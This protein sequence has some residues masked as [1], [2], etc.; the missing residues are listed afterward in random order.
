MP[1]ILKFT[2]KNVCSY[3][4]KEQEIPFGTDPTLTLIVGENGAGKTTIGN[5][6]EFSM[7]GRTRKRKLKELA[8]RLNGHLE[9]YN[10]FLTD[11]GR[12][13]EVA[14]GIEP[15][16]FELKVD[17]EPDNKA[18]KTRID[19][20]I[21]NELLDIPFEVCTNTMIL[22]INDFKSFV[23]IKAEDKRKIVD[24]IFGTDILNKMNALLK[25]DLKTA[26]EDLEKVDAIIQHQSAL[27]AQWDAQ[28]A[29]LK[30]NLSDEATRR[31]AELERLLSEIG[32]TIGELSLEI[33]T[34]TAETNALIREMQ[35]KV[36][37]VSAG[38]SDADSIAM[39]ELMQAE[40]FCDGEKRREYDVIDAEQRVALEALDASYE[41]IIGKLVQEVTDATA[42]LQR[43]YDE[44]MVAIQSEFDAAT[45]K[46]NEKHNEN[47]RTSFENSVRQKEEILDAYTSNV[48]DVNIRLESAITE[49]NR[50]GEIVGGY[51]LK[52]NTCYANI[53]NAE[54]KLE[55][56]DS[57]KCPE[58][59]GELAGDFHDI[60]KSKIIEEIDNSKREK[61]E[62]ATLKTQTDLLMTEQLKLQ[63]E[64]NAELRSLQTEFDAANKRVD[65]TKRVDDCGSR[66]LWESEH[67]DARDKKAEDE[68]SCHAE[69]GKSYDRDVR[70]KDGLVKNTRHELEMKKQTV[71]SGYV[72]KKGELNAKYMQIQH[73]KGIAIAEKKDAAV[74]LL[75][76]EKERVRDEYG[77]KINAKTQDAAV[78][79]EKLESL[80]A[81][82]TLYGIEMAEVDAKLQGNASVVSIE[83]MMGDANAQMVSLIAEQ[84]DSANK[85]KLCIATQ[86]LLTEDGI[87][88]RFM[89]LILP[90]MNS[91]IK[92]I[93]DE[94]QYKFPFRF[95]NDFNAVIEH[96]GREI[97]ADSLS[98]GEEKMIDIIVVLAVMELIKMKHPKVNVMFL[99]EI[100][101]SLDQN[102]IEKTIKI[103]RD[104]IRRYDM[105]LFAISHTM[106]PK[107]YFDHVIQVTNDGM[108]SD[109]SIS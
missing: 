72:A 27:I 45:G 57:G 76:A 79:R 100:F 98:T 81:T 109:L 85:V 67:S 105:S 23:K 29:E 49:Y 8:N 26:K 60:R 32:K 47:I 31:K 80:N 70:D 71:S 15:A 18:G 35:L 65:D 55:L 1:R 3:G 28:L 94:F 54:H 30:A 84:A 103:L 50:L 62:Y 61:D 93:I 66:E 89:S 96:M 17:G 12:V 52:I 99:D 106:M 38:I 107:E 42:E 53:G 25:E 7:Y 43:A 19:E 48:K 51:G 37:D 102:N 104:F 40:S 56:Y 69:Y 78:K 24:R 77:L 5:A 59:E 33:N 36:D 10:K 73:D 11:D 9:T 39:T 20:Y 75:N 63:T 101:A 74:K 92:K 83:K 95:D 34:T 22:S 41:Q 68:K 21:E 97:S 64:C 90:T 88:K 4:N 44:K 6:L 58:C 16:Y 108:F 82:S 91:M 14:R 2:Y 13:V 86:E 46:A 87:K